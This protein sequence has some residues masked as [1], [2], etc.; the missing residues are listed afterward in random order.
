MSDRW[1][2]LAI[3][4]VPVATLCSWASL[5]GETPASAKKRRPTTTTA[6]ATTT[7]EPPTTTTT[8]SGT[9]P[10]VLA[11]GDIAGCSST[12]DSE[13]AAVL[14]GHAGTVLTLG[15]NVYD[16]GTP[17][18]F[19]D[20]YEPTWGAEKGR[21]RPSPGNHD[22]RTAGAAGYYGYFG[23]AAGDPAEGYYSYDLGNWHVVSLNSNCSIV[24]C[25]VG[26]AQEQWLRAD[27]A[28]NTK[29]CTVA[30]WHHPRYSSGANHGSYT[31]VQPLWQ[32]LYDSDAE[33]VLAGHEHNYERFAPMT[34][35]GSVD[36]ELG[37][38]SF[39][40]GTGGRSHYGFGAPV[41]GSEVGDDTTFGV[42]KLTLRP[43]SYDWEFLPV[44]GGTFT[45]SGTG[46]CH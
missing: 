13:T 25:Q 37:I 33:L 46:P 43:N 20:C 44:A 29:P 26:S 4:A 35:T 39:V 5:G 16:S 15:D 41:E 11:A 17:A 8:V 42:L 31:T 21:T 32:A 9:D 7:T 12:G 3:V 40:V 14:A 19:A 24:S 23:A 45:D 38:R 1:T 22:Y 27:L 36:T 2:R 30:Y 28:A 18:E 34:A 6:P 10:V